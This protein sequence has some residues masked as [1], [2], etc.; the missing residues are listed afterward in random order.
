MG[1]RKGGATKKEGAQGKK[2]QRGPF[3]LL[4]RRAFRRSPWLSAHS[5]AEPGQQTGFHVQLEI[6][7][8][9]NHGDL[10]EEHVWK[11]TCCLQRTSKDDDE[12][13]DY[14]LSVRVPV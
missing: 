7:D 6:L 11:K 12:E 4:L 13:E 2:A 5:H 1:L 10:V 3:P 8:D 9:H 14:H